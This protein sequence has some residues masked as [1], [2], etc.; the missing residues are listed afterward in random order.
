VATF[1]RR[2]PIWAD[3]VVASIAAVVVYNVNVTKAGAPLSGVWPGPVPFGIAEGG[4]TA[5]YGSLVVGALVLTAAGLVILTTNGRRNRVV[6]GLVVRT[7][8]G[9]ALAGLLGLLLDYRDGP[10]STVHSFVYLM[11]SLGILRLAR[12]SSLAFDDDESA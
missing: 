3:W 10:V 12:I 7:Y 8:A 11:L 9:V 2:L 4:R 6:G 1:W 5:F